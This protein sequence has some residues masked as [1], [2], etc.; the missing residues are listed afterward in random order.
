MKTFLIIALVLFSITLAS[1]SP[2]THNLNNLNQE[3]NL[4]S[5]L[6]SQPKTLPKGNLKDIP[7]YFNTH[8]EWPHCKLGVKNQGHCTSYWAFASTE[9]LSDRF[10]ISTS[11]AVTVNLSA[12]DLVSCDYFNKGCKGGD[13]TQAWFTLKWKGVVT[14]ACYP[15]VSGDGFEPACQWFNFTC[16]DQSPVTKFY[17]KDYYHFTSIEEIKRNML[18]K[19]PISTTFVLY[20]D[21]TAHKTGIYVRKSDHKIGSHSVKVVGWGTDN[22]L[23]YWIAQ[24]SWGEAWGE[25]GFFK[26]KEGECE[27]EMNMIAGDPYY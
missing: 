10:C 9:V 23:D 22:N 3:S 13:L 20:D 26:I 16:E 27:F 15:Y 2:I 1:T 18:L 4:K 8:E 24:N 6:N 12:Q 5:N 14:D 25:A 11:G 17:A 19:G 21:F 7:D